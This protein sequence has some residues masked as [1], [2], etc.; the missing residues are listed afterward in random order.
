MVIDIERIVLKL[1]EK[2][3][4]NKMKKLLYWKDL[5]IKTYLR[6]IIDYCITFRKVIV[7]RAIK[8]YL[9]K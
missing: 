7:Q 6:L 8:K 3:V 4:N 1:A 5:D 9:I 2:T